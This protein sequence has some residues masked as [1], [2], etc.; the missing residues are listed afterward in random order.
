ME[1][2]DLE[3]FDTKRSRFKRLYIVAVFEKYGIVYGM[4]ALITLLCHTIIFVP[5]A[6]YLGYISIEKAISFLSHGDKVMHDCYWAYLIVSLVAIV[7]I[8]C[9]NK[10]CDKV[11]YKK[12]V[13]SH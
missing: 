13:A 9:T 5:A 4:I 6:A 3:L 2:E 8:W 11:M 10:I 1:D 12:N 7:A